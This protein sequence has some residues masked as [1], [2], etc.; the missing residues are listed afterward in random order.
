MI[1][2]SIKYDE[3]VHI[4]QIDPEMLRHNIYWQMAA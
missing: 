3:M 2:H 1:K 4:M